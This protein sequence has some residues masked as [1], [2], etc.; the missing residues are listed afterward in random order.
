MCARQVLYIQWLTFSSLYQYQQARSTSINKLEIGRPSNIGY[1]S[2]HCQTTV[3]HYPEVFF[4]GS[5]LIAMSPPAVFTDVRF[6]LASWAL[7]PSM[8]T[9]VLSAFSLRKSIVILLISCT[10][11]SSLG[12]SEIDTR[13][14]S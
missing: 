3:K 12:H 8:T 9:S 7:K 11:S 5:E 14:S 13:G 10:H 2:C 4:T 6:I 1:L